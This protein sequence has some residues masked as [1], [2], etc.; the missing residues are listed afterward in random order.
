MPA[1]QLQQIEDA[2]SLV[3]S[4]ASRSVA[5]LGAESWSIHAIM[6]GAI[7]LGTMIVEVSNNEIDWD[8]FDSFA[9]TTASNKMFLSNS[10][11]VPYKFV[12]IRWSETSAT[13]N[14]SV[15]ITAIVIGSIHD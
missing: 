8:S 13:S 3:I 6:A 1:I 11:R 2:H 15:T 4:F 9:V 14:G 10:F 12:R 7:V 5:V